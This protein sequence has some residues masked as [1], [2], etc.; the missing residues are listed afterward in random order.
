MSQKA[1]PAH[2]FAPDVTKRSH[3]VS[4]RGPTPILAKAEAKLDPQQCAHFTVRSP[5]PHGASL[6]GEIECHE[7]MDQPRGVHRSH[8]LARISRD[9]IRKGGA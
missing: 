7:A 6:V 1:Y 2:Y 3:R 8:S 5:L 4:G 9:D